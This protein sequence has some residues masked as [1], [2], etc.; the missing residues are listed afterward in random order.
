[1]KGI[2]EERLIELLND[3]DELNK[4]T[5]WPPQTRGFID[6]LLA[7]EC[8]KLNPWQPMT[9]QACGWKDISTAPKDRRVMLFYLMGLEGTGT[10]V[11][12]Y[13][14]QKLDEE[15][16]THWQELPMSPLETLPP[17]PL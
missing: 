13:A 6:N 15:L 1:M 17:E 8:K 14:H 12:G 10:M 7:K 2:T 4:L 3:H 5:P 16:P 9:R 11:S